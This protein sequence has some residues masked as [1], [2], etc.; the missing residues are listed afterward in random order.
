M[1]IAIYLQLSQPDHQP[2]DPYVAPPRSSPSVVGGSKWGCNRDR[3]HVGI[4]KGRLKLMTQK[5]LVDTLCVWTEHV[6]EV[7]K[8]RQILT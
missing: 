5:T 1:T 8:H 6:L 3:G 2:M 4:D 7:F